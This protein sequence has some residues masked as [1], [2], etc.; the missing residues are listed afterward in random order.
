MIWDLKDLRDLKN[1]ALINGMWV[2]ARPINWKHRSII[3]KF[4]EAWNV[5][6]GKTD[7]FRWPEG[8]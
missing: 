7:S 3:Q 6:T 8:Q 5:F 1:Q 4:K 2:P